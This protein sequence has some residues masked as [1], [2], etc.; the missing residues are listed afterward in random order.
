[1]FVGGTVSDAPVLALG[2]AV[3]AV[4]AFDTAVDGRSGLGL[5]AAVFAPVFAAVDAAVDGLFRFGFSS[6][7]TSLPTFFNWVSLRS[8]I[9]LH[10]V[11]T[12]PSSLRLFSA[13][14]FAR[15]SSSRTFSASSHLFRLFAFLF[16]TIAASASLSACV[17]GGFF[18]ASSFLAFFS[19]SSI[20]LFRLS[21]RS[22][23][24]LCSCS[25]L[26][27]VVF[28]SDDRVGMS[29]AE[30]S[31]L[32]RSDF[33]LGR[34]LGGSAVVLVGVGGWLILTFFLNLA[35]MACCALRF[36]A[37]SFFSRSLRCSSF[38]PSSS[39]SASF[40]SSSS[41]E[42]ICASEPSSWP[43]SLK[44]ASS[45][46]SWNSSSRSESSSAGSSFASIDFMRFPAVDR[47]ARAVASHST[48]GAGESPDSL[49]ESLPVALLSPSVKGSGTGEGWSSGSVAIVFV[50][51]PSQA[52]TVRKMKYRELSLCLL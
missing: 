26:S 14:S 38:S 27:F 46:S 19:I 42:S 11:T 2:L 45:S 5:G 3:A 13:A 20:C 49:S 32:A 48:W 47:F 33:F 40:S 34:G 18:M 23:I 36:R 35:G 31:Q 50:V 39:A 17:I 4:P 30:G 37:A 15:R 41:D 24:W 51:R 29:A 21:S 44:P 8:T 22:T 43:L 28:R 7:D 12:G 1:M 16:S 52:G 9:P 10:M 25:L 6:I